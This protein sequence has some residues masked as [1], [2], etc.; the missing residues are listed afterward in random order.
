MFWCGSQTTANALDLQLGLSELGSRLGRGSVAIC[1]FGL[2]LL[3]YLRENPSFAMLPLC[4]RRWL[5]RR[6]CCAE[7]FWRCLVAV[8]GRAVKLCVRLAH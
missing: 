1:V 6:R 7:E 4:G 3:S 2:N 5:E 8:D